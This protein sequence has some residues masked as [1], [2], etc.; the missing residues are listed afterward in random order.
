MSA[1]SLTYPTVTDGVTV[2]DA[3]IHNANFPEI[4]TAVNSIDHTNMGPAGI[5]ASNLLPTTAAQAT[6]GAT[7]TGVGYKFL[8]NDATA[9]PLTVSGVSGQSADIFDVTLTSG[10]TKAAYVTAA[11]HL[12]F[13]AIASSETSLPWI[14]GDSGATIGLILNVPTGSTNGFRF[15]VNG[16]N[17][18]QITAAGALTTN[19]AIQAIGAS[20]FVVSSALGA[21]SGPSSSNNGD[22]I[23]QRTSSTG[24]LWL[25]GAASAGG[26]EWNIANPSGFSIRN[27]AN[28]GYVTMFGTAFTNSSDATLKANVKPIGY[29]TATVLSLKPVSFDW[30]HDGTPSL[31]FLAQDVQSVLPELVST[32][33]DGIMGVNYAGM[34]PV[35]VQA[36][37]DYKAVVD[38]Y[39]AAHP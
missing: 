23:G 17:I 9:V 27:A 4:Q 24:F 14:T 31:G 2:V 34:I 15:L 30:K 25:G 3:V 1:L 16:S 13:G 36:F 28:T 37:Q 26:I 19:G 39:M 35:L 33:A 22:F 8:A 21:L 29:G 6:F 32:D 5:Y 7:A 10:G 11:G 20:A 12:A 18:A 38:A